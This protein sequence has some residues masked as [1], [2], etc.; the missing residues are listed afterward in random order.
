MAI[1]LAGHKISRIGQVWLNDDTI[2]SFGDKADYE[3]HND[4]KRVDPY[5][6]KNA[7]SWK[8]DMIGRG[9]AWLRLTLTYDAEKFPYGVPNVKVEV[10]GKEIFDP[11]SNRT[12]WSNNGALVIL[13]FYRSYLKVPDSDIDFNVFK[14]AADLCDESVTTPEGKSKPRYTLNGAYELSES[15][16]SILEHMHRCIGAEPTYI[17]GQHGILMWAYH[18]PATLKIEPH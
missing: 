10:W 6:V 5:L 12:N 4:R 14:V 8:N 18:G 17:A 11:R 1:T 16:A 9:L 13:D 2:G 15:P 3:L 7:P